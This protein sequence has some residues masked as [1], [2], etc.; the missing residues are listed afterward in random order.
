[1]D[2]IERIVDEAIMMDRHQRQ[3]DAAQAMKDLPRKAQNGRGERPGPKD[4]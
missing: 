2:M 1:M 4:T 3:R